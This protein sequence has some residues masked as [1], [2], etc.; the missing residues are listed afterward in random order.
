M[1]LTRRGLIPAAAAL[2]AAPALAQTADDD[3]DPPMALKLVALDI[4]GTLIADHGE[5]QDAM[6]GALARHGVTVTP[7]ELSAWRGASKRAMVAHFLTLRGAD[8][9]L[10]GPIY[11]DFSRNAARAYE[12]V[13]PIAG[14]AAAM[15]ALRGMGLTLA[16]TTGFDRPLADAILTRLGW[17]R[18]FAATVTSDEVREGRP[19]PY[20]LF[21]AMEGAGIHDVREVMAVGDTPLDLQAANNAGVA[22]AIGVYSGAASESRL[23]QE[24]NSG[25]LPSVAELPGLIQKGLPLSHCR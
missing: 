7:E 3:D 16:A 6:L 23:R 2:A 4:G 12:K 21:R 19:A 11:D 20:L 9:G 24:R 22:A 8:A 13:E 14:A 10:A 25:V 18:H 5:V 17:T 1:R 15:A